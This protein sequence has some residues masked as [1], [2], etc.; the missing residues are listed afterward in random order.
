M[1]IEE[2]E[3][4]L[5]K[6]HICKWDVRDPI[7]SRFKFTKLCFQLLKKADLKKNIQQ[8]KDD[9]VCIQDGYSHSIG[10]STHCAR[11]VIPGWLE[12]QAKAS[13]NTLYSPTWYST[14]MVCANYSPFYM[15]CSM[16][17]P[18][19]SCLHTYVC[20]AHEGQRLE[21]GGEG[22]VRQC[23]FPR[24]L[25]CQTVW[26]SYILPSKHAAAVPGFMVHA[27]LWLATA[28]YSL[29]YLS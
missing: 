18:C 2:E 23:L 9:P 13:N 14:W 29:H 1:S 24:L 10:F 26:I 11:Q 5:G 21:V 3:K 16:L 8:L 19:L 22:E 27:L 28:L 15:L 20:E 7:F 4:T 6:S 12:D 25:S 17:H